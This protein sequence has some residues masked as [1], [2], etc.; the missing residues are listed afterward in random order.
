LDVLAGWTHVTKTG[1]LT[2]CLSIA[3]ILHST[4][5][6]TIITKQPKGLLVIVASGLQQ[7]LSE[8]YNML[9]QLLGKCL[10]KFMGNHW[11][12]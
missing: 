4:E 6:P 1:L 9:Q 12:H 3:L 11:I 2:N 5:H 8:G 7:V 10:R